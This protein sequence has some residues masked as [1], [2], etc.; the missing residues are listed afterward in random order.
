MPISFLTAPFSLKTSCPLIRILPSTHYMDEA[1]VCSKVVIMDH[2]KIVAH[3]T[4]ENLKHQYTGTEV[5]ASCTL[6]HWFTKTVHGRFHHKGKH[7]QPFQTISSMI[8]MPLTFVSGA[9]IPTT[10]M[11]GFLLLVEMTAPD[12]IFPIEIW[13][14]AMCGR[15]WHLIFM[16]L[17]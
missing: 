16:A 12:R 6:I 10:M 15:E 4:P 8:M 11:P 14:R 7:H 3:D 9:Y 5:D 13:E 17:S 2:G 1:E